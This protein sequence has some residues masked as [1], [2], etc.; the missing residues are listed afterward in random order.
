MSD[1]QARP[2]TTTTTE[3]N[4]FCATIWEVGFPVQNN[5]TLIIVTSLIGLM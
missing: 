4:V 2:T 1:A 3:K 5:P